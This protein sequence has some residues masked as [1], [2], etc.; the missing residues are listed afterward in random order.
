MLKVI[1][2]FLLVLV[3]LFL[4][5]AIVGITAAVYLVNPNDFKQPIINFVKQETGRDF[6][7]N[8]DLGW[9]FFPN[10]G[11]DV[12]EATLGNL[13]PFEKEPFASVKHISLSIKL[14]TLFQGKI[15]IDKVKMDGLS[16]HFIKTPKG[17]S[18]W[19]KPNTNEIKPLAE[20]SH[21]TTRRA[22]K[23]IS[24][25]IKDF[26]IKD[27]DIHF[28]DGQKDIIWLISDSTLKATNVGQNRPFKLAGKINFKSLTAKVAGKVLFNGTLSVDEYFN[29]IKATPFN[30]AIDATGE[31]FPAGVFSL[32]TSGHFGIDL[33]GEQVVLENFQFR[34]NGLKLKGHL[35]GDRIISSP[36]FTGDIKIVETNLNKFL[37][38]MGYS[39]PD[40]NAL[41]V[42]SGQ[43]KIKAN[44]DLIEFNELLAKFDETYL[45]G[46]ASFRLA[47]NIKGEFNLSA[48]RL[49]LDRYIRQASNKNSINSRH[50]KRH[51][52]DSVILPKAAV[53]FL[54]QFDIIGRLSVNAFSFAG[55]DL[56]KVLVQLTLEKGILTASPIKASL[57]GG[58]ADSK[59][60]LDV[61]SAL[62]RWH[63]KE[64]LNNIQLEPLLE[65]WLDIDT[66]KGIASTQ[67]TMTSR[68]YTLKQ[69][70][71]NLNGHTA[72]S[73]EKGVIK[74]IDLS[75]WW[76]AGKTFL[77][78]KTIPRKIPDGETRFD[79]LEGT[80]K[81]TNGVAYNQ[82]LLLHNPY[83]KV[84]GKGKIDLNRRFI[85]Y[86]L[87]VQSVKQVK[88]R[89]GQT[90]RV[91]EDDVIPL[92]VRGRLKSPR[93]SIDPDAIAKFA[94]KQMQKALEKKGKNKLKEPL[95]A[96][97]NLIP[98]KKPDIPPLE[99]FLR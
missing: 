1:K 38:S 63:G 24:I 87:F 95:K 18:N 33:P 39:I 67:S 62:P 80:F 75:F 50:Q 11:F 92:I 2:N 66:V 14:T 60:T 10:I 7:I 37:K 72:F 90:E 15:K 65:D 84:T 29:I 91:V 89:N 53:A 4:L 69:L 44:H 31:Q 77:K 36:H 96:I 78:R 76:E 73:V 5:T 88:K 81:M 20:E 68:G 57:Y 35:E 13:P 12:K 19:P 22:Q 51:A 61:R 64:T 42:F 16:M 25:A 59:L 8:G 27:V 86:K 28:K 83:L 9:H 97:E 54:K 99:S 3:V 79:T 17:E 34:L 49:D 21:L 74:G 47:N 93:V 23:P 32:D 70:T 46:N 48:D 71:H 41:K 58:S 43:L 56:K 55:L 40:A 52:H 6:Y 30:L 98:G 82:D 26:V 85:D 45:K 94:I